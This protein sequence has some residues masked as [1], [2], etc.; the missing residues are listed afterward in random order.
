MATYEDQDE[1]HYAHGDTS[2]RRRSSRAG[3]R[4]VVKE[5]VGPRNAPPHIPDLK[6]NVAPVSVSSGTT[7]RQA[8]RGMWELASVL[9]FFQVFREVLDLDLDFSAEELETGLVNAGHGHILKDVHIAILKGILPP[10]R[11]PPDR[12]TWATVLCKKVINNWLWLTGE[13][14]RLCPLHLAQGDEEGMYQ[15][16]TGPDRLRVLKALC[17]LRL[18]QEDMRAHIDLQLRHKV[19]IDTFQM[20]PLATDPSGT[21]Y[22]YADDSS[23]GHRLYK[24]GPPALQKTRHGGKRAPVPT[25]GSWEAVACN[26]DEFVEAG[27][28]LACSRQRSEARVGRHIKEVVLPT[29]EEI[30]RRRERALRKQQKQ[31]MYLDTLLNGGGLAAGRARRERKPVSYTFDDFER[32]IDAAIRAPKKGQPLAAEPGIRPGLR[33]S[34]ADGPH[35]GGLPGEAAGASPLVE[36]EVEEGEIAPAMDPTGPREEEGEEGEEVAQENGDAEEKVGETGENGH[37]HGHGHGRARGHAQRMQQEPAAAERPL[38][39][40]LR[41]GRTSRKPVL[42]AADGADVVPMDD[43]ADLYSDSDIEGEVVYSEEYEKE[44]KRKRKPARSDDDEEYNAEEVEEDDN[45]D[46]DEFGGQLL[47]RAD[48]QSWEDD[49]EEEEEDEDYGRKKKKR[50]T[51]GRKGG[52]GRDRDAHNEEG[53]RRSSRSTKRTVDYSRLDDSDAEAEG[54]ANEEQKGARKQS[55][56]SRRPTGRSSVKE[57]ED[58]QTEDDDEEDEEAEEEEEEEDDE[59]GAG[60]HATRGRGRPSFGRFRS[61]DDEDE[62]TEGGGGDAEPF[63]ERARSSKRERQAHH[64]LKHQYLDNE[65]KEAEE[66]QEDEEDEEAEERG[67]AKE[68]HGGQRIRREFLDLNKEASVAAPEVSRDASEPEAETPPDGGP[69]DQQY[70]EDDGDDYYGE[71]GGKDG[72]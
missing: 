6:H 31:A 40:S 51:R 64:N 59:G 17:E 57:E 30:E 34:G 32:S 9:H 25:S 45:D 12:S 61:A 5:E 69:Q 48:R 26:Y 15:N 68:Q 38:G 55:S 70:S 43:V 53:L 41:S 58:W 44:R 10:T 47:D 4:E 3:T 39:T 72:R 37:G 33:S 27:E 22:W 16:L 65:D 11:P 8:L 56:R 42:F 14:P 13:E 20:A 49:D 67:G 63:E 18:D 35:P 2:N 19:P 62:Y 29:L 66:E 7:D 54:W 46:P 24:E 23:V 28:R 36:D 60:G 52:G 21:R 50:V 71:G 1:Y